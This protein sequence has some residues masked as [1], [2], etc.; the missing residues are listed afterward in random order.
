MDKSK[1]GVPYQVLFI[2]SLCPRQFEFLLAI[3][4]LNLFL[5]LAPP[6]LKSRKALL[7]EEQKFL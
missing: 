5:G 6:P 7:R 2:M 4:A 1:G 3:T